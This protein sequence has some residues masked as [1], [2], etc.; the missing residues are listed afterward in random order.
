M[1]K[2]LVISI[3]TNKN[4]RGI[5]VGSTELKISQLAD[6]TTLLILHILSVK[7]SLKCLNDFRII[8]GLKVNIDKT[9]AK[10]I[11]TL[12]NSIP[13][14][15]CGIKWTTRPLTTLGITISNNPVTI[16]KT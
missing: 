2:V 8:S 6:D 4:V 1:V 9:L 7:C 12:I 10:G 5:K 3:R 13:D 16:K 15:R 11:R 14:D